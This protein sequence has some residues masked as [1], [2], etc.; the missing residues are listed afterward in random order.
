MNP[1]R[2][3]T[4]LIKKKPPVFQVVSDTKDSRIQTNNQVVQG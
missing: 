1:A 2:Y 4:T 3:T